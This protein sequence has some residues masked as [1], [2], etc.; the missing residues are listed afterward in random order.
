MG[1]KLL[2]TV[3]VTSYDELLA[4]LDYL[5]KLGGNAELTKNLEGM[6][7]M[8]TQGQ[9]LAG[10][11]TKPPWGLVV[12]T[13]GTQFPI[14]VFVPVTDLNKTLEVVKQVAGAETKDVGNG[15][16]EV[17]ISRQGPGVPRRPW[18]A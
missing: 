14:Y 6:L 5:G 13:D 11:D 15:V 1:R 3:S 8:M 17:R 16:T 12:Q 10:I 18:S 7:T 4:D 2:L 9:G